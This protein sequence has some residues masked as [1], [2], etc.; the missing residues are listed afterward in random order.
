MIIVNGKGIAARFVNNKAVVAV[1]KG[2]HLVWEYLVSCFGKGHWL[3]NG[4][5]SED[6]AWAEN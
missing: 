2:V 6:D 5:W 1:Y 4:S 3:E